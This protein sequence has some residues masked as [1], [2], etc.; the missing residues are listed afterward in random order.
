[1]KL[2]AGSSCASNQ[3]LKYG[4]CV[5]CHETCATCSDGLSCD[6][7]TTQWPW[8]NIGRDVRY[9]KLCAADCSYWIDHWKGVKGVWSDIVTKLC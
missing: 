6:T 2:T 9:P 5:N 3:Y 1:M 7:C 4:V 8:M